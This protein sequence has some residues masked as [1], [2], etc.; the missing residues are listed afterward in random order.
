M[1]SVT[2]Q[3]I[4]RNPI[5]HLTEAG[6]AAAYTPSEQRTPELWEAL[7]NARTQ[8]AQLVG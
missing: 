3:D 8:I 4:G 1:D 5:P 6:I 7:A 2:Y